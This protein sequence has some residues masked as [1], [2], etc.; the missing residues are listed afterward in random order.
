MP[1]AI[2]SLKEETVPIFHPPL[3]TKSLRMT[4]IAN[5]ETFPW[6]DNKPLYRWRLPEPFDK[7]EN[8]EPSKRADSWLTLD[9]PEDFKAGL[10]SQYESL[11]HELIPSSDS[12]YEPLWTKAFRTAGGLKERYEV[13]A[14]CGI[15]AFSP[16]ESQHDVP[17]SNVNFD[18]AK[19]TARRFTSSTGYVS[20][21]A[22][23]FPDTQ[24]TVLDQLKICLVPLIS[25]EFLLRQRPPV[26]ELGVR[27]DRKAAGTPA[28]NIAL[29]SGL[30][31]ADLMMPECH[32]DIR[33]QSYQAMLED[34]DTG[35]LWRPILQEFITRNKLDVWD[36]KVASVSP[37][38]ILPLPTG[39]A[40]ETTTNGIGPS[41]PVRYQIISLEYRTRLRFNLAGFRI[42]YSKTTPTSLDRTTEKLEFAFSKPNSNTREDIRKTFRSFYNNITTL[43][44]NIRSE[45]YHIIAPAEHLG[46]PSNRK[47]AEQLL[48][49]LMRSTAVNLRFNDKRI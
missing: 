41:V 18:S 33:F 34:E 19:T 45:D 25:D 44:Y 35:F 20:S 12:K 2:H 1:R 49:E 26:V 4:E 23:Q 36:S 14:T 21:L 40:E 31:Y 6:A 5:N 43:T 28:L 24:A 37:E 47:K 8:D 16:P 29:L 10:Q 9:A 11:E 30:K 7:R 32:A 3:K 27:Y 13:S 22:L 48:S 39:P 15:L 38:V 42:T 17:R 46:Q